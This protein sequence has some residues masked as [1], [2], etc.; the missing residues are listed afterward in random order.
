MVG[1]K[2][3]HTQ[4]LN[5]SKMNLFFFFFS[6]LKERRSIPASSYSALYLQGSIRVVLN[7]H[8]MNECMDDINT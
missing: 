5:P 2:L 8:L 1:N 4:L 6:F 7:I 3:I